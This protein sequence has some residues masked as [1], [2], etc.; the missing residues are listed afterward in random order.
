MR[1][2]LNPKATPYKP[3]TNNNPI[4]TPISIPA[5]GNNNKYKA[6]LTETS[7]I[8]DEIESE[9]A[10]ITPRRSAVTS[11]RPESSPTLSPASSSNS[12][13]ILTDTDDDDCEEECATP[14]KIPS[15]PT[16]PSKSP[17]KKFKATS[18]YDD[19]EVKSDS[20]RDTQ[21]LQSIATLVNKTNEN[22]NSSRNKTNLKNKLSP[23]RIY[24]TRLQDMISDNLPYKQRHD[25]QKQFSA[26]HS[27]TNPKVNLQHSNLSKT[28]KNG[29]SKND[30]NSSNEKKIK[31]ISLTALLNSEYDDE[32]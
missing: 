21:S 32:K 23:L 11:L 4:N 5:S 9:T 12:Y 3:K 17:E 29:T 28:E 16:S 10:W 25:Y 27:V 14:S 22:N 20:N 2:P 15:R 8:L 18:Q 31:P 13:D 6:I 19:N 24:N 26:N 30:I 7:A 1:Q